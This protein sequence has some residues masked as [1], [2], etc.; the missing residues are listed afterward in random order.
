[1]DYLNKI[2]TEVQT[3]LIDK[4]DAVQ[5]Y[6]LASLWN[7]LVDLIL[8]IILIDIYWCCFCLIMSRERVYVPPFGDAKPIDNLFFLCSFYLIMCLV[9]VNHGF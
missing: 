4:L 1:M 9:K 3:A 2:A 5:A 6:I 7:N 8:C